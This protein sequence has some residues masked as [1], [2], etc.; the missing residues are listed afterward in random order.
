MQNP[1]HLLSK[2]CCRRRQRQVPPRR[3]AC[4]KLPRALLK[5]KGG[6]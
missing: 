4:T 2:A 6:W 3:T 5:L 1:V